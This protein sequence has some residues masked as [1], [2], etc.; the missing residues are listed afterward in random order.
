MI[1]SRSLGFV[2]FLML[3]CSHFALAENLQFVFIKGFINEIELYYF[4]DQVSDLK[5]MG[6]DRRQI[7]LLATDSTENLQ[8][9]SQRLKQ[10][11]TR[12]WKRSGSRPL[13]LIGHSY[14]GAVVVDLALNH[15]E[16]FSAIAKKGFVIQ[17]A[18]GG[19]PIADV[20]LSQDLKANLR[21]IL[22]DSDWSL[23]WWFVNIGRVFRGPF[24]PALQSLETQ[25]AKNRLAALQ[26][27]IATSTLKTRIFYVVSEMPTEGVRMEMR[28]F[29]SYLSKLFGKNDGLLL[30]QD[31]FVPGFGETLLTVQA[32]HKDL[33]VGFA[34]NRRIRRL[35]EQ[36]N[37]MIYEKSLLPMF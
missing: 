3:G 29:A 32:D 18:M 23:F 16:F 17:G 34:R 14:G 36:L 33:T 1:L 22:G 19:S 12:I 5:K 35:R 37:K 11:V 7:H 27:H 10:E 31:Q 21:Q 4:K 9:N 6:V 8:E 25:T 13:I 28:P 30:L 2:V 24:S 20:V 15:P 26:D